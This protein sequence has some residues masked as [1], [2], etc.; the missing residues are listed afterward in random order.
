[1]INFAELSVGNK[2]VYRGA[3]C[4]KIEQELFCFERPGQGT[5]IRVNVD[6][7][8]TDIAAVGKVAVIFNSVDINSGKLYSVQSDTLIEPLNEFSSKNLEEYWPDETSKSPENIDSDED[9]TF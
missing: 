5:N 6:N 8:E 4:I 2:F 3:E 9:Y 1:M 7:T